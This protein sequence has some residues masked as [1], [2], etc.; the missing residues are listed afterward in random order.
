M[1]KNEKLL[2][3]TNKAPAALLKLFLVFNTLQA[4]FTLNS[5]DVSAVGIRVME[6]ILLN[7]VFSFVVFITSSEIKRYSLRWSWI[8]LVIGI[9]QCLRAFIIPVSEQAARMRI[10]IPLE[11]AGLVLIVASVWSIVQ[12]RK[13][14]LAKKEHHAVS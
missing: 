14:L 13:Y 1:K 3:Q 4:I 11:I 8:G 12:S 7:I 10:I 2:Y 5:I 6:I 9:I